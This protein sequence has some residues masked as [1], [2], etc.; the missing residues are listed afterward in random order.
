MDLHTLDISGLVTL[1]SFLV[2]TFGA[3]IIHVLRLLE[4]KL[5]VNVQRTVDGVVADGVRYAEQIHKVQGLSPAERENHALDFIDA[6]LADHRINVSEDD[7]R[8]LIKKAVYDLNT[9]GSGNSY[10]NQAVNPPADFLN[11]QPGL[12][13]LPPTLSSGATGNT[14]ATP[15]VLSLD[16]QPGT[17]PQ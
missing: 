16:L 7:L 9:W 3:G 2:M 8:M 14:A 13:T 10:A 1:V 6:R 5:P 15:P 12:V 11:D 4:L 17:P